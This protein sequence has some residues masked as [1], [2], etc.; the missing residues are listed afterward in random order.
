MNNPGGAVDAGIIE[1]GDICGRYG[2]RC[3][4]RN[5]KMDVLLRNAVCPEYI[6]IPYSW[7][8]SA[9]SM[10]FACDDLKKHCIMAYDCAIRNISTLSRFA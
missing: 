9:E 1:V 8:S 10:D 2:S 3:G 4:C 7:F 5:G 6:H